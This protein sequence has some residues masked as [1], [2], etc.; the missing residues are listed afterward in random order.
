MIRACKL[1]FPFHH[2]RTQE[3]IFYHDTPHGKLRREHDII[4]A[5]LTAD[6]VRRQDIADR[7]GR[8]VEYISVRRRVMGLT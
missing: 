2:H 3:E 4:I 5:D 6:G 8:S 1:P 7:I